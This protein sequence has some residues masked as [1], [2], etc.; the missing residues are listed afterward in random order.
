MYHIFQLSPTDE[1]INDLWKAEVAD[2]KAFLK[3]MTMVSTKS[4]DDD[5]KAKVYRIIDSFP[6]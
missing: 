5:E 4:Q 3:K 2:A 6:R 1:T